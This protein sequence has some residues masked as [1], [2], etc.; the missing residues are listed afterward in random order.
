MFSGRCIFIQLISN[1]MK[2]SSFFLCD[3]I[4]FFLFTAVNGGNS[5]VKKKMLKNGS[6]VTGKIYVIQIYK[7]KLYTK[8]YIDWIKNLVHFVHSTLSFMSFI[9]IKWRKKK[10]NKAYYLPIQFCVFVKICKFAAH[11]ILLSQFLFMI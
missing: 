3:K 2:R 5:G 6:I 10:Q 11:P 7:G 9:I 1:F 4:L 8:N